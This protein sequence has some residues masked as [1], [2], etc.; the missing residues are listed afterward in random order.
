MTA[1]TGVDPVLVE[2]F[3][4]D[5]R[6]LTLRKE[7]VTGSA[8]PLF[9]EFAAIGARGVT[10]LFFDDSGHQLGESLVFS[11]TDTALRDALGNPL[12]P[13]GSKSARMLG[14]FEVPMTGAYRFHI[15]FE[16]KGAEAELRMDNLGH[17]PD[18]FLSGVASNDGTEIGGGSDHYL[19]LNAGLPYLFTFHVKN[20]NDGN[21]RLLLQGEALPKGPFAQVALYPAHAMER[22]DQALMLLSKALL[23]AQQLKLS[24]H[25]LRYILT[26]AEHFDGLSLT[27]LPTKASDNSPAKSQAL[28]G[29]FLRLAAYA[30]LKRELS[31]DT[32]D[33]IHIF[34]AKTNELAY[35]LIAKLTRRDP[36]TV[37]ATAKDLFDAPS[38]KN[39]MPLQRLWEALEIEQ[40]LGIAATSIRHWTQIINPGVSHDQR[41]AIARDLRSTVKARFET[42]TWQRVAQAIFDKLRQRQ[43]D[44]L[45]AYIAH[46]RGFTRLEELFEYFLVDPGMEPV[47]Q[48][49]RIRLA[50]SAVQTFV[51]RCLLNLEPQVH[52][53]ALNAQHWQWMKAYRAWEANRKIFLFPENWLEPE[54]R[55][56]MTYLFRDL[57][58]ALLQDDV[59]DESA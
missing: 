24:E 12:M 2:S 31:S 21:V 39:E 3:L 48:T 58:G 33:I 37:E 50:I 46:R 15:R 9:E 26:H 35:R 28:F 55:D 29:Q 11:H 42:Q 56:D 38:F 30:R 49:S 54:F 45:V 53:S 34:Q 20:L 5:E 51:Q 8:K 44:A 27:Q 41:F 57:Q 17:L 10:A 40:R 59:S 13:V 25:E 14:Y 6:L 4:N 7:P 47:V 52:P 22:A 43:R 1:H 18:P 36:T 19:E 23:I 32:D 16:R